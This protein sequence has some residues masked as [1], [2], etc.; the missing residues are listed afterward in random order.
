MDPFNAVTPTRTATVE[1]LELLTVPERRVNPRAAL[2]VFTQCI[3]SH[4]R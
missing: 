4:N 1:G 2:A 3:D